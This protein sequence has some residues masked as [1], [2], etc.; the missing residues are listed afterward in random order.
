MV[1]GGCLKELAG[2]VD[3]TI[4]G[5]VGAGVGRILVW[6]V[7][8]WCNAELV[9]V[10]GCT[11]VVVGGGVEA[12]LGVVDEAVDMEEVG[13]LVET[14]GGAKVQGGKVTKV[15]VLVVLE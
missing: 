3:T 9:W 1:V 13:V 10:L 6:V 2:V 4:V 5:E 11:V 12:R 7:G 8:G 15:A 14:R